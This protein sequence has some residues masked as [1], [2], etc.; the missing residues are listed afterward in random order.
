[1][2]SL[3]ALMGAALK[4]KYTGRIPSHCINLA[5]PTFTAKW[6]L[7]MEF[8]VKSPKAHWLCKLKKRLQFGRDRKAI[9]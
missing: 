4:H 7:F 2:D 8:K 9:R 1:M 5:L 3:G 6:F